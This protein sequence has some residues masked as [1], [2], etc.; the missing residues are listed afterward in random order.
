MTSEKENKA[1]S[2]S[3]QNANKNTT[4]PPRKTANGTDS[5]KS[6]SPKKRRKV[7]H[8]QLQYFPPPGYAQ[9]ANA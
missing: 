3:P 7:N 2:G 4:T 5:G 1:E 6:S 8:G 9:L